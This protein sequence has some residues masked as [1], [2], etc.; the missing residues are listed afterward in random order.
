MFFFSLPALRLDRLDDDGRDEFVN[1]RGPV[2]CFPLPPRSN[3]IESLECVESFESS[4][5]KFCDE[6][7]ENK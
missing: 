2:S 4:V 5:F 7:F 1:V 6:P 3:E